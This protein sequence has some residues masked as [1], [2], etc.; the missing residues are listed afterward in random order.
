MSLGLGDRALKETCTRPC[1]RGASVPLPVPQAPGMSLGPFTLFTLV[2]DQWPW[3]GAGRPPRPWALR[4]FP[5]PFTG[6]RREGK[7]CTSSA[8]C[9]SAPQPPVAG[10][11]TGLWGQSLN[12][13]PAVHSRDS[14][15]MQS[16][17]AILSDRAEPLPQ[18]L[19]TRALANRASQLSCLSPPARWHGRHGNEFQPQTTRAGPRNTM[20]TENNQSQ[21]H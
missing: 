5:S 18:Q 12:T 1:Q 3:N 4:E 20:L 10:L 15:A 2:W 13:A 19:A 8:V 21:K 17:T 6:A 11:C 9:P 16:G 14:S 7:P